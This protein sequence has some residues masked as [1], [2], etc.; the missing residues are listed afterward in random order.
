MKP[1][2]WL[3]RHG[4]ALGLALILAAATLR[5][6]HWVFLV[7]IYQSPDEPAHLAYVEHLRER[8][9][10]PRFDAARPERTYEAHQPPLGY[11][12][13]Y[14]V[15][16]ARRNSSGRRVAAGPHTRNGL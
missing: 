15:A 10:L 5:S 6:L 3:R 11:A 7:P 4:W 14:R 12:C 8:A 2:T 16:N 1:N 9:T 13:A